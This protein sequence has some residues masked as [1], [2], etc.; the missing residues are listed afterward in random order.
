MPN[1]GVVDVNWTTRTFPDN[2][3]WDYAFYVVP[4]TGAHQS[5]LTT[6]ADVL[7]AAVVPMDMTFSAPALTLTHALGYSYDV[8]PQFMYCAD[9]LESWMPTTGGSGICGLSGGSSGGPWVQ[10]MNTSTGNGP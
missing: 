3:H 2:V 5:G 1:F 4:D 7:D 6:A 9:T 8:D 10:P